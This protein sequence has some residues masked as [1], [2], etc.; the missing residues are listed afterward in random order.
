[1]QIIET[2]EWTEITA[3]NEDDIYYLQANSDGN[4]RLIAVPCYWAQQETKPV[5]LNTDVLVCTGL[6]IKAGVPVFVKSDIVPIRINALK[7]EQ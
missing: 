1:M 4:D 5:D 3:L 6:K 2:T 7:V